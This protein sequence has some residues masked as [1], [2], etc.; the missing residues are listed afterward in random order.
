MENNL[1]DLSRYKKQLRDLKISHIKVAEYTGHTREQVT[2]WLNGKQP[3]LRT[4]LHLSEEIEELIAK[5]SLPNKVKKK[6]TALK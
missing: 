3:P 4:A 6:K 2:L 1:R 5:H